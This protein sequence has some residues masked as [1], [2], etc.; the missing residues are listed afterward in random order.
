MVR[1]SAGALDTDNLYASFKALGDVLCIRS[2]KNPCGL[3]IIAGD[4]PD[5]LELKMEQSTAAPGEGSTV[6]RIEELPD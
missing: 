2:P 5:L 1:C 4:T 3:G 6:V